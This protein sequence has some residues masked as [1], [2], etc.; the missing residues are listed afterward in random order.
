MPAKEQ[1]GP[2][3]GHPR[4]QHDRDAGRGYH[5]VHRRTLTVNHMSVAE[6]LPT[7]ETLPA[8]PNS[9]CDFGAKTLELIEAA[10]LASEIHPFDPM[11]H[12]L[13]HLGRRWPVLAERRL[14]WTLVHEF[15]LTTELLA[16][17]HVW[18]TEHRDEFVVAAKGDA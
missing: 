7:D 12:A 18:K 1:G 11:E 17:A 16:M 4:F 9:P 2:V 13:H 8:D 6:I 3:R 5:F 10:V 15:G 14:N